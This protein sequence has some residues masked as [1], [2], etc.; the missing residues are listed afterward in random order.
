MSSLYVI[1]AAWR[2]AIATQ[3]IFVRENLTMQYVFFSPFL[4]VKTPR[5]AGHG[6]DENMPD[7]KSIND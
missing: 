6:D 7:S 2:I 1:R 3:I 5:E 4:R